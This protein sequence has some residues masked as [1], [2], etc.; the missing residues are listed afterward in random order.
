MLLPNGSVDQGLT[1]FLF[2][3]RLKSRIVKSLYV[4]AFI[5]IRSSWSRD[6]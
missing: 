5:F 4:K 3:I 1:L 2:Q 6:L